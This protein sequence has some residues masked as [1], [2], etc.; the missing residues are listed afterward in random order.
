MEHHLLSLNKKQVRTLIFIALLILISTSYVSYLNSRDMIESEDKIAQTFR[1]L[2]QMQKLVSTLADAESGRRAFFI[3]ERPIYLINYKIASKSID[4]I[5]TYIKNNTSENETQQRNLDTLRQLVL[6]RFDLFNKS[7]AMQEKKGNSVKWYEPIIEESHELQE[8]VK[9]MID[10]MR[11]EELKT[12]AQNTANAENSS[13][14]TLYIMGAGVLAVLL[15][16]II[17]FRNMRHLKLGYE[18]GD[19]HTMTREELEEVLNNRNAE[20]SDIQRV[21]HKKINEITIL[22]DEFLEIEATVEKQFKE[23]ANR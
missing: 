6:K 13:N 16:F 3:M 17:V 9:A 20:L 8:S 18:P 7:L 1:N 2:E 21:L 12:L 22:R 11:I 5:W 15:I 19:E 10:K 14:F 23:K 4:T